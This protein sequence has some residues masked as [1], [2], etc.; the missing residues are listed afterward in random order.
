MMLKVICLKTIQ[1]GTCSYF[2][3]EMIGC[4]DVQ[5]VCHG[6]ISEMIEDSIVCF[7]KGYLNVYFHTCIILHTYL[8]LILNNAFSINHGRT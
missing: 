8:L 7:E 3:Q 1:T 5:F 4:F 2:V 6:L